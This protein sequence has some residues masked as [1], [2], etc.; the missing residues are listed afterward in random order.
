MEEADLPRVD[1]PK[2]GLRSA[3]RRMPPWTSLAWAALI[4]GLCLPII[5]R[6]Y[7][8]SSPVPV[9]GLYRLGLSALAKDDLAGLQ[10][11]VEALLSQQPPPPHV[12]LLEGAILL[13]QGQLA[14]AV[15]KLSLAR[16]YPETAAMA[17]L[18][19][20]E[21]LYSNQQLNAAIDAL[22]QAIEL[23]DSLL[24]AHRLLAAAYYDLGATEPAIRTLELISRRAS[25]DP[26]PHRLMGIIYKDMEDFAKAAREFREVLTRGPELPDRALVL[27]DLAECLLKAGLYD[28]LAAVLPDCPVTPQVLTIAANAQNAAGN[29]QAAAQLVQEALQLQPEFLEALLL[30]ASLQFE[31]G[32]LPLAAET[33]TAAMQHHPLNY[34]IHHQLSQVHARAGDTARAEEHAT[35]AKRLRDLRERFTDLHAR[36]SIDVQSAQL[37]YDLAM[38]AEQLGMTELA[39]N[40]LTQTLALDRQHADAR[41]A[42]VSMRERA[43]A[44]GDSRGAAPNSLGTSPSS[45]NDRQ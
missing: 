22:K 21:A 33:L 37:R 5:W 11:V 36:A 42:L 40:W 1:E 25:Q 44:E 18:L 45:G 9:D 14:D 7:R 27:S 8:W 3:R 34:R 32:Q 23:D 4:I 39:L 10:L 17:N 2:N 6:T 29:Q 43:L 15:T 19:A 35:E 24:D 13:R 20:G 30:Q 12:Q 26:R 31:A 38:T 41:K 28:D 16:D